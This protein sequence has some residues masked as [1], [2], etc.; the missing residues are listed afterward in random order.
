MMVTQA[1]CAHVDIGQITKDDARLH[2][3]TGKHGLFDGVG[4]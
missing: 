2:A 3:R 4:A 1:R